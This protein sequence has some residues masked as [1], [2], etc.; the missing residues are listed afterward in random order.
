[1]GDLGR[2]GSDG[3]GTFEGLHIEDYIEI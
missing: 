1:V 2:D 3:D